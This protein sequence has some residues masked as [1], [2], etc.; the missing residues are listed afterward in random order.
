MQCPPHQVWIEYCFTLSLWRLTRLASHRTP[1]RS[2]LH[3]LRVRPST[4]AASTRLPS[5]HL[6]HIWCLSSHGGHRVRSRPDVVARLLPLLCRLVGVRL[7]R[8]WGDWVSAASMDPNP[9][10]A[11]IPT[12]SQHGSQP[13]A[14]IPTRSQHGF[15]PTARIPTTPCPPWLSSLSLGHQPRWHPQ[16]AGGCLPERVVC[17]VRRSRMGSIEWYFGAETIPPWYFGLL[18]TVYWGHIVYAM[19]WSSRLPDF[20]AADHYRSGCVLVAG[21]ALTAAAISPCMP[22]GVAAAA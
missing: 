19:R 8:C 4:A 7:A 9:Q 18:M 13:A 16:I 5:R 17:R 22:T 1:Y 15:Q 10:L 14:R 12:R 3:A 6:L 2:L 21:M 11:R 20:R